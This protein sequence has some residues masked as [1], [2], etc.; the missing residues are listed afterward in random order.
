MP[1]E[2]SDHASE[3]AN[4]W[5]LMKAGYAIRGF[6]PIIACDRAPSWWKSVLAMQQQPLPMG[7]S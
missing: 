7:E 6:R 5:A 1:S 4:A 2:P 3:L